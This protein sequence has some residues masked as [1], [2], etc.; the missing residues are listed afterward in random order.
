MEVLAPSP[1]QTFKRGAKPIFPTFFGKN[2]EKVDGSKILS[3]H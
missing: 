3:I 1:T 2:L